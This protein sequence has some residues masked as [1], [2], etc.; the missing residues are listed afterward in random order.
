MIMSIA[1][2]ASV[3]LGMLVYILLD[4]TRA[5][6]ADL[7]IIEKKAHVGAKL[8]AANCSQCHGPLGEGAIGPSINRASWKG[9]DPKNDNI[10]TRDFLLKVLERGQ[11]SPQPGAVSMP[12]WS[13][14]FGGAFDQEQI[15]DVI[16]FLMY[17]KWDDVLAYTQ[18]PNYN[19]ELPANEEQQKRFPNFATDQTQKA[20]LDKELK[21]MK[22][23]LQAKGCINCHVFGSLGSSLGPNLTEI[24]SR[25]TAEWL[26]RWIKDPTTIPGTDRGPNVLPW[27]NL[28]AQPRTEPWPMNETWMPKIDM[29]DAERT[30]IVNYLAGL[31]APKTNTQQN[32]NNEYT[33]RSLPTP[34]PRR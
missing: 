27:F 29:T 8:F 15:E 16:L 4:N 10:A 25:R 30:K 32:L 12:A 5:E 11:A 19:A 22:T 3:V 23:L 7:R 21:E 6:G 28:Y 24:G 26:N 2:V 1:F 9:D 33:G 18:T 13:K 20:N 17:G 31:L 34:T 14:D